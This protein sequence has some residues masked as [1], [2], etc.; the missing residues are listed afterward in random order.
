VTGTITIA[1]GCIYVSNCD[2]DHQASCRY[3][4]VSIELL[5]D[6]AR[7]LASWMNLPYEDL[8]KECQRVSNRDQFRAELRDDIERIVA[9]KAGDG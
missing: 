2:G 8:A 1:D 7:V 5:H 3:D 6:A 4:S 9:A